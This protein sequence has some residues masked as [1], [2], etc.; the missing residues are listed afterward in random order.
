MIKAN[1]IKENCE[2]CLFYLIRLTTACFKNSF[3][4]LIDV[5]SVQLDNLTSE[6]VLGQGQINNKNYGVT[7]INKNNL[8]IRAQHS[9]KRKKFDA[10]TRKMAELLFTDPGFK[11]STHL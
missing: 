7:W 8:R 10:E 1:R 4:F 2:N 11:N 3:E 5:H 9:S 6:F